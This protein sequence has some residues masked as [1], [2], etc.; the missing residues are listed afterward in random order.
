[1]IRRIT[2][3]TPKNSNTSVSASR[4]KIRLGVLAVL[5][6]FLMSGCSSISFSGGTSSAGSQSGSVS[7]SLT[8]STS[9]ANASSNA[10]SSKEAT[11]TSDFFAMDTYMTITANGTDAQAAVNAA[12]TEIYRLENE[13]SRNLSATEISKINAKSGQGPVTVSKETFDIISD[14]VIFSEKTAGAFDI[15]IAPIMDIWGFNNGNFR[16]PT[17]SE[18]QAAL[19]LVNWKQIKLDAANLTVELPVAGMALDLGGIAKG[20]ASDKVQ[21]VM[22]GYNITSALISL[23]GNVAVFGNKA[24]GSLW[25]IAITDPQAIDSYIGILKAT[26]VSVITSGGYERNFTKNG[27]TYIHIM[28]PATGSPVQTDLLSVSIVSTSGV[29]GDCLSTALFVMGKDK[30]IAYWQAHKDFGCILVTTSGAV[31]AS[32]DLANT[33]MLTNAKGSL[34][35]F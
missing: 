32:S 1:M 33:F 8:G 9:G 34:T 16:V 24:D 3:L 6:V 4:Y 28:D 15:T 22:H 25:K 10:S 23:G 7:G 17:A 2:I 30:A 19:P 13:L 11:A 20:Y 31:Y 14:A 35:F 29:Q 12:Q 26:D 21:E 5:L 18:I 27:K